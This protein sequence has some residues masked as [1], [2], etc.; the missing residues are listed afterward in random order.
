VRH[1]A[2]AAAEP[3][4]H[5]AADLEAAAEHARDRGAW[6]VT[7]ALLRRS[8]ALTPDRNIRAGREVE[9]AAAE[10]VIGHPDTA[11][12]VA[13]DA[14]PRLADSGSRGRAKVVSGEAS[15][16][17]ATRRLRM[18]RLTRAAALATDRAASADALLAAFNA[19]ILA[20]R[21]ETGGGYHLGK[22]FRKLNV[23]S[24]TQL[25]HRLPGRD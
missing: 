10:L 5:L 4:E 8:V 15:P 23:R 22:V 21:A 16:K 13:R 6:S 11:Q 12:E 19:A 1:R 9:L 17:A 3:D 7:A 25:A 20:G 18:S 2:A 24:R 14:L